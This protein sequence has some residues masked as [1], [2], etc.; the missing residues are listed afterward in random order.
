MKWML[1]IVAVATTTW[2][3]CGGDDTTGHTA[4]AGTGAAGGG[5][6]GGSLGKL[7]DS[8]AADG[9]CESGKCLDIHTLDDGCMP[10][11]FCTVSCTAAAECPPLEGN[12]G[13]TD[14]DSNVCIYEPWTTAGGCA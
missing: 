3:A 4:A 10:L 5:G 6:A 12:T 13:F 1:C 7:G 14:C 11:M 9:E 2:I 8:C